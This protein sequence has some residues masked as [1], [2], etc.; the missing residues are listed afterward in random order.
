MDFTLDCPTAAFI[1]VTN[2]YFHS[3]PI[4][5]A[6]IVV[7]I[8][9]SIIRY[10]SGFTHID[11]TFGGD[12]KCRSISTLLPYIRK[13][14]DAGIVL[15]PPIVDHAERIS[16][17]EIPLYS[18]LPVVNRDGEPEQ[19]PSDEVRRVTIP[20]RVSN[21]L[22]NY[23]P[24]FRV[25]D[26]FD[27]D[28]KDSVEIQLLGPPQGESGARIMDRCREYERR[29][30]SVRY[31]PDTRWLPDEKYERELRRS[32]IILASLVIPHEV[33]PATPPETRGKTMT[34]GNIHDSIRYGIPLLIPDDFNVDPVIE[35]CVTTYSNETDLVNLLN[36]FLSDRT[37]YSQ[38]RSAARECGAR[39]NSAKQR[40]RFESIV[41]EIMPTGAVA[42]GRP[43]R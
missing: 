33:C 9:S 38:L 34:T 27:A 7:P 1:H 42:K 18:L 12:R 11:N 28:L 4:L 30:Y 16:G 35:G 2:F 19:P 13:N 6:R 40:R 43:N 29:V 22:R 21:E 5:D 23:D 24:V 14:W 15:Y 3:N 41:R 25:L 17:T 39:F 36:D 26:R 20:G 32:D 8:I 37:R 10:T 31:Y